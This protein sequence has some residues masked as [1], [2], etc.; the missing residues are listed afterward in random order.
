M[1]GRAQAANEP[2]DVEIDPRWSLANE[3]TLLAYTRTALAFVVAGLAIAGSRTVADAPPWLAAIGLPF[4]ACGC[5]IAVAGRRRFS[6]V[7][8]ALRAGAP[9]PRPAFALGL[10][11]GLGAL[12]LAALVVATV[13]LF[14]QP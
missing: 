14:T 3:R 5:A 13:Q 2:F 12:A 9:I 4:V 8:G 6:E 11:T 7:D 1:N 10:S